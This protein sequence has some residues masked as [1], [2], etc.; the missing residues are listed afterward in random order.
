[1][2][3][4]SA[5]LAAEILN[6]TLRGITVAPNIALYLALFTDDPTDAGL[7]TNELTDSNY[8][9]VDIFGK[10]GV[11]DPDDKFALNTVAIVFPLIVDAPVTITHGGIYYLSS[12]GVMKYSAAFAAPYV[13]AV[14]EAVV[15]DV[16]ALRIQL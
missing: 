14:D 12:G 8:A 9:R 6:L 11:P 2:S 5:A 1:M 10:I 15:I 13:L 3:G 7:G 4:F 16:G